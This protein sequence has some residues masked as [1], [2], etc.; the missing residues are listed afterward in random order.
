MSGVQQTAQALGGP[1]GQIGGGQGAI[2][3][4]KQVGQEIQRVL[5]MFASAPGVDQQKVQ[6]AAALIQQA[7]QL[8]TAS[9]PQQGAPR[10]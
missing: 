10:Q 4:L 1:G 9:A 8:L 2:A 7:A 6:Q 3:K 5:Q